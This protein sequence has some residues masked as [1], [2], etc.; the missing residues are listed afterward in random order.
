MKSPEMKERLQRHLDL[1]CRDPGG[2]HLG[3]SGER[4]AV[5][6]LAAQFEAMGYEVSR[7]PFEAPGWR[8]ASHALTSD[9]GTAFPCFP[10]FYS[11]GGEVEGPLALL[12]L[13]LHPDTP[14]ETFAGGICLAY[15][16]FETVLNTN[17][18][19]ERF[20]QAGVRALIIASPYQDTFSTKLIRTPDLRRLLVLTV[21]RNTALDLARERAAGARFR[22]QVEAEN[23]RYEAVNVVARL[24]SAPRAK[25]FGAV[26]AHFDTAPGIPG[27]ADNASGTAALLELARLLKPRLETAG[28]AVEWVACNAEE[29]A[30]IGH[31]EYL[32]R[33]TAAG[34]IPAWTVDI[35]AV[36]TYLGVMVPGVSRSRALYQLVAGTLEPYGVKPRYRAVIPHP[37]NLPGVPMV[38]FHEPKN[39]NGN[40]HYPLHSPHDDPGLVDPDALAGHTQGIAA[41]LERML[42]WREPPRPAWTVVPL[43]DEHLPQ[44]EAIVRRIWT[45]GIDKAREERFGPIGGRPWDDWLWD[46]FKEV[47]RKPGKLVFVTIAEDRVIGF[48]SGW[49]DPQSGIAEVGGNGVDPEWTGQGVGRFQIEHLLDLFRAQGMRF[50]EVSTGLNGGHLPARALYE[51]LGFTALT[52]S[53]RYAMP[54]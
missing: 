45:M 51:A 53:V 16:D 25:A 27:A 7:E 28:L 21:S 44:I 15:G 40:G 11:C 43:A 4:M 33:R 52:R 12:N 13:D 22:V 54:L 41:V 30:C 48:F 5:D 35:D 36:G 18:L 10:C 6:Y 24:G 50:A 38:H 47:L 3:S 42:D 23:F 37:F 32:R 19:A 1:L 14:P 31:K 26:A 9:G 39:P 46:G 17:A 49:T 2:R 29:V 34:T 20:D 8:L